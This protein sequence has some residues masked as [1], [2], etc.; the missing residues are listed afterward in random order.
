MVYK[1][2]TMIYDGIQLNKYSHT[3]DSQYL[4]IVT[5]VYI[6]IRIIDTIPI[7][8]FSRYNFW[9]FPKSFSLFRNIYQPSDVRTFGTDY[10]P[11]ELDLVK[12]N[13]PEKFK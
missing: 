6:M 8:S 11:T 13:L 1:W 10:N 7:R 5:N 2:Y 3:V 9:N 12:K 4:Y